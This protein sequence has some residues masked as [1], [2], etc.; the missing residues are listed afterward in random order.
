MSFLLRM[1][2]RIP[3]LLARAAVG[4]VTAIVLLA[5]MGIAAAGTMIKNS[6]D[7]KSIEAD[8]GTT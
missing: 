6:G 8:D 2:Y 5:A 1:G 7:P 4:D 3:E